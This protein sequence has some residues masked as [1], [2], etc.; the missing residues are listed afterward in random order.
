MQLN[1]HI[2]FLQ[3]K[4]KKNLTIMAVKKNQYQIIIILT[5]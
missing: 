4:M 5:N 3:I 2:K 1:R